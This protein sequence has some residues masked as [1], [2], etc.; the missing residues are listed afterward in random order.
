MHVFIVFAS[1]EYLLR[2]GLSMV[3]LLES[4][5]LSLEMVVKAAAGHKPLINLFQ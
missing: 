1:S 4:C 2:F 3:K 5:H